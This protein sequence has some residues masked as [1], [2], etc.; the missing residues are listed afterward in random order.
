MKRAPLLEEEGKSAASQAGTGAAAARVSAA[1][2]LDAHHERDNTYRTS[3]V[4]EDL[5]TTNGSVKKNNITD[6][7]LLY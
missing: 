3:L 7:L 1:R 2:A 4:I 5:S 6:L